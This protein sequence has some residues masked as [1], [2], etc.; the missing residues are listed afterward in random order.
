MPAEFI[1]HRS[2][3]TNKATAPYNFV[4]LPEKILLAEEF[5]AHDIYDSD[6]HTGYIELEIKTE[7]PLYTRCA[8]P[9]SVYENQN[10]FDDKGKLK[11]TS[12]LN[13]QQ[14]FHRGDARIPVIPGST[15]RGMTRNLVEIFSYSK[16]SNVSRKQLIYRAVADPTSFGLQY[17]K[18]MMDTIGNKHFNY[19]SKKLKG[20]YLEI[21]NGQ[22]FIRPA[23]E[24]NEH[25]ES[26]VLVERDALPSRHRQ[27]GSRVF[28]T[29][30]ARTTPSRS[31][32]NIRLD[33]A[34]TTASTTNSTGLVPA[35]IVTTKGIGN[36]KHMVAA[37]YEPDANADLIEIPVEMWKIYEE[38]RDMQRGI[39]PIYE[40]SNNGNGEPLFY[41]LDDAG[42]L[43]FFGPTMMFRLRYEYKAVDLIPDEIKNA[44]LDMAESIFG[45][46][47]ENSKKAIASRV[48][49]SDAVWNSE[50][51]N[52]SPFLG[53]V[54]NGRRVPQI[55]S[56]P[57]PTSFQHYLNQNEPNHHRTD[58][59][60]WFLVKEISIERMREEGILESICGK[61]KELI[62]KEYQSE[63]DY[64]NALDNLQ[65]RFDNRDPQSRQQK[66]IILNSSSHELKTYNDFDKTEIRGFKSYWHN[67]NIVESNWSEN[68][69]SV[70]I[71]NTTKRV[72]KRDNRGETVE[73]SQHT[74]IKPVRT[75]V[76][77]SGYVYFENLSKLELG[78]LLVSLE[79]PENMRHQ[80]GMAKPYGLGTIKIKPTLK[81]QKREN[82]YA[83]LF[84]DSGK[85]ETGEIDKNEIEQI[86]KDS[87]SEFKKTINT[88]V[89]GVSFNKI[90]RL[91]ELYTMLA[92]EESTSTG[93]MK[94][95]VDVTDSQWRGRY[96][97]PFPSNIDQIVVA[98][99]EGDV[100][101]RQNEIFLKKQIEISEINDKDKL[102]NNRKRI[103]Q[104]N[105]TESQKSILSE[106]LLAKAKELSVDINQENWKNIRDLVI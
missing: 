46:V 89:G 75:N 28:V 24:P 34:Y 96:V 76:V 52:E 92:W 68:S 9:T 101:D 4:P 37:I 35:T 11:V 87:I 71:N 97:L 84:A 69:E 91:K 16:I 10:N 8:F 29:P 65:V 47:D 20:G 22:Y 56:S 81:I 66:T 79:L 6:R 99:G 86:K 25:G 59:T 3:Q 27:T 41:L 90:Q 82:R 50:S 88:L 98:E 60:R 64:L 73:S 15:L 51:V 72:E 57:K 54:N 100:E 43:Y 39:P 42:N 31:N 77:F 94:K 78:A 23:Q 19:P 106:E 21:Q 40:L 44:G 62:G 38:D 32:P 13:C 102:K 63:E 30:V 95:Y 104:L 2:P 105:L 36:N 26:F 14:F 70:W 85:F 5:L 45:M 53:G 93:Y 33:L 7:T 49:F 17:R 48:F 1:Q 83:N 67:K 80:I 61:I 103:P 74:I 58:P 18:M 55:L 12:D